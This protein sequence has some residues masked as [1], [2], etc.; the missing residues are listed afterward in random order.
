MMRWLARLANFAGLMLLLGGVAVAAES[1]TEITADKWV[2]NEGAREATFSGNVVIKQSDLT[3]RAALVVVHYGAGG[4][5]DL[6]DFE[7]T[8]NVRIQQPQQSARGDRAIYNPKTRILRLRGNVEVTNDAGTIS[9]PEL[10][11]DIANGTS[12][13]SSQS[14]GGRVTGI[15]TPQQ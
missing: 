14:G 11:V 1:T 10:I 5:S 7:A 2:V 4:A 3:V 6:Q 13:F 9:G 8:G 12:E 15:F